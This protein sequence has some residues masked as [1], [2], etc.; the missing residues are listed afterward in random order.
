MT[1][2]AKSVLSVLSDAVETAAGYALV[3]V[4]LYSAIF[5]DMTG[6]GSLWNNMRHIKEDQ[7]LESPNATRIIKVPT[8]AAGE[9][10]HEDRILAVFDEPAKSGDV[11]ALYPAP[12]AAP[13]RPSAAMTD[14]P[15]DPGAGKEWKR[16]LKGELRTFT[17]YGRG[18]QTSSAS[19]AKGAVA[20]AAAE[21]TQV[22][23]ASES[24]AVAASG[25][26]TASRPGMGSHLSHGSLSGSETTRNVR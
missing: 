22:R 26:A 15:A 14:T 16:S 21:P 18:D 13:S 9:K 25:A 1:A 20:V 6:G 17:V 12:E 4:G 24:A 23:A 3:A 19:A 8:Q 10:P 5:V 11:A 2:K 7:A